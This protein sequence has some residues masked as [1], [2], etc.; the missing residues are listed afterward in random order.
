MLYGTTTNYYQPTAQYQNY[1]NPYSSYQTQASSNLFN[2][3]S[4]SPMNMQNPYATQ[5][6]NYSPVQQQTSSI[7]PMLLN[8]LSMLMKFLPMLLGRNSQQ[9]TTPVS[10][11]PVY[12]TP[13]TIATT[14]VASQTVTANQTKG[15]AFKEVLLDMAGLTGI[16]EQQAAQDTKIDAN[17][18]AIAA[19]DA[20]D[21]IQDTAINKN[22]AA[23]ATNDAKDVQQEAEI[24][25][26]KSQIAELKALIT[27]NT[28]KET[29]QDSKIA[30]I[31]TKNATQDTQ[32]AAG[33]TKDAA[34]DTQ[35]AAV[36]A[37][38]AAQDSKI[39][40]IE[41]KNAT[42]DTQIAAGVTKDAAQ[43]TKIAAAESFDNK[44][45]STFN[46]WWNFSI[47]SQSYINR[48]PLTLD[49]NKDGKVSTQAGIGVDLDGDD[50]ADGA[51]ID[52]DKMLAMSDLNKNG[53]IDASEV[54]GTDTINAFTGQKVNA[55]NGFE[56][57]KEIADSAE[58]KTGINIT[59]SEG[60]VNITKLQEALKTVNVNLGLISDSNVTELENLGDVEK[61]DLKF[62]E[63][64]N[65]LNTNKQV[66]S[67]IT[68]SGEKFKT[69]DVW[70][71]G[72]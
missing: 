10:T 62:T 11:Q 17:T 28:A 50:K 35:I 38:D 9:L 60:L 56:A 36:V 42:Q 58:Q 32:I 64:K 48:D 19:N 57:L 20:K 25:D 65:E 2:T 7:N 68:K 67:Y 26:L 6:Y 54:F 3:Q 53:K 49:I 31:E 39:A 70:F 51:A 46:S 14:P 69:E 63:E 71:A 18:T 34:Q 23:I 13:V 29:A 41:T 24:T 40:A 33:V 8:I 72:K 44:T 22:T 4:F 16:K 66:S 1:S 47:K 43:D 5:S 52:G 55:R 30:A 45:E 37:K 21:V 27:Q 15:D 59:D 61:I 12:E